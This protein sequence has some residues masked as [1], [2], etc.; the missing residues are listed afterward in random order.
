MNSMEFVMLLALLGRPAHAAETPRPTLPQGV[1]ACESCHGGQGQGNPA[2]GAPRI[3]G[4]PAAYLA[5]QLESFA[6]GSRHNPTMAPIAKSLDDKTRE[7]L[8]AY[9]STLAVPYGPPEKRAKNPVD[10]GKRLARVGDGERA[11]QAC[12]NCHG[13]DGIGEPPS[14][15]Y[16]AGLHRDY[17]VATLRAWRDGSRRND[18]SGQMPIIAKRMKDDE[19]EAVAAY[20]A[21]ARPPAPGIHRPMR[22][23][24]AVPR[25][26]AG[27]DDG[28]NPPPP[29]GGTGI[30]QGE[31][32]TGGSQGPGG[33]GAANPRQNR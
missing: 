29:S 14:Y 30:E 10:R 25:G 33:G 18:A 19:I 1:I 12:G 4:Q 6:D 9:Y 20:Y 2:V 32:T 31:P 3:A 27:D 22:P 11:I 26:N 15:P 5:R 16:L 28:G 23:A 17:L 24:P 8:A 7:A 13:P 21:A